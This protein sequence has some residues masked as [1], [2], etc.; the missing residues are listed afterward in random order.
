[1]PSRSL[2]YY[3]GVKYV[4]IKSDA[5]VSASHGYFPGLNTV[6]DA[7]SRETCAKVNDQLLGSHVRRYSFGRICA[8][9][10]LMSLLNLIR[11]TNL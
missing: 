8:K 10:I 2:G 7:A 6:Q 9:T 5:T 3:C 11:V 1:V 4:R